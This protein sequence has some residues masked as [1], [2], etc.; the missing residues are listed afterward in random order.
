MFTDVQD[1]EKKRL[2]VALIFKCR[3]RKLCTDQKE[4]EEIE[5][6]AIDGL[7]SCRDDN[8]S[9]VRDTNSHSLLNIRLFSCLYNF[10]FDI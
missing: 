7:A 10:L 4:L 5:Y 1:C 9:T 2:Q 8:D 6:E 3:G